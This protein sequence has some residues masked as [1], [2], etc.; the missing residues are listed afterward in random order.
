MLLPQNFDL[1]AE[2][3]KCKTTDDLTGKNGLVQRLLGNMLGQ[4][5]QKEMDEHLGYEKHSPEGHHSGNSRNGRTKKNLKSNYGEIEL[6]VPRDRNSE[7]EP[8]VIKKHQRS[9]SSFDDKIISMYAKGMTVR[10]IQSHIQELYG[11]EMSPAMVSNITEKV[12]EVATEWQARPLHTVYPVVF[13]DAIHYKVKDGGKVVSKAAYTCLG[14]NNE[15][16]KDILGLWIGESEGAKFWLKICTE[17]QSRGVKDILIACIDGLKA[18]PDAI[19]A[20]F[21]EVKIQLCVIHMIRNSIKYIPTKHVK[22]FMAELKE[23]YGAATLDLAEQNLE[24]LQKKWINSYPLAV[25]PWETHW[26]NIKTFFEFPIAIRRIIYT[27]NAV[28][29]LHRQFRKVTKNKAVFPSDEAL[30]KML[31][32]AARDVSKKWSLPLKE[33]KSAISY[34]ALAF[35]DRLDIAIS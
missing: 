24:V 23:V 20:V 10:D 6:E 25:K 16:K 35:G 19:R 15:G 11:V 17:L 27:T 12:V 3:A 33:W 32:L 30:F 34:L 13:F 29:S 31:F 28:E 21:P 9:I 26:H 22:E 5:L 4:M 7:F 2:L 14:I 1:Q 8:I 18:L